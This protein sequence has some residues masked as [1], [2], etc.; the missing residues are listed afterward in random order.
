MSVDHIVA[1]ERRSR[2]IAGDGG[3]KRAKG[4]KF[5]QPIEDDAIRPNFVNTLGEATPTTIPETLLEK[6]D[7]PDI[8]LDVIIE[9]DVI[10]EFVETIVGASV[11]DNVLEI[12]NTR[13][14]TTYFKACK[15]TDT[16][17]HPARSPRELPEFFIQFL[18]EH[19]DTVLDIFAGSNTTDQMAQQT[20]R[21]WL[22]FEYQ[23]SYLERSQF[24][25]QTPN[26]IPD[27]QLGSSGESK[28]ETT[29]DQ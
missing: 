2:E 19:G 22:T 27:L 29:G 11:G 24:R 26:D 12:A 7:I 21:K 9:E 18:T 13:S 10:D 5:D 15:A 3:Q 17:I 8:L 20:G 25:F 1:P 14:Q 16:E 6:H 23:S 28:V 4:D